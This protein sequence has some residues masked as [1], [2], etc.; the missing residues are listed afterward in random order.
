LLRSLPPL[1]DENDSVVY[2]LP[3]KQS[4]LSYDY[5]TT[6]TPTDES[7]SGIGLGGI[8]HIFKASYAFFHLMKSI[9]DCRARNKYMS[10]LGYVT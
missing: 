9:K 3:T 7:A 5:W 1:V 4:P 6:V 8:D 10:Q 2:F